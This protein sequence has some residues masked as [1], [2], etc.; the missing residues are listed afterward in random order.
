MLAVIV[1]TGWRS[2]NVLPED[3]TWEE[4]AMFDALIDRFA[5]KAPVAVGTEPADSRRF[6]QRCCRALFRCGSKGQRTLAIQ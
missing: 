4:S 3:Q 5:T 6:L 1:T 2:D